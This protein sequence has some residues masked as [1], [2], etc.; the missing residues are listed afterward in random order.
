MPQPVSTSAVNDSASNRDGNRIDS[1]L[2]DNGMS[3][4]SALDNNMRGVGL[5]LEIIQSHPE[6]A[7]SV[8]LRGC[9][10]AAKWSNT[11]SHQD[12]RPVMPTMAMRG[13]HAQ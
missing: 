13:S 4:S 12:H 7:E 2:P 1:R 6:V 3:N 10:R 9:M 8:S 5:V 11:I